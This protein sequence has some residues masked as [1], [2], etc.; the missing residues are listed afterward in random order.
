MIHLVM[1]RIISRE[2]QPVNA[3]PGTCRRQGWLGGGVIVLPGVA[4]G[5]PS[6]VGAG[7]VGTKDVPADVIVVG[8]P[9]WVVRSLDGT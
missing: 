5:A 3:G 7:A 6:V 9:A 8:N 2:D 4:I 1:R